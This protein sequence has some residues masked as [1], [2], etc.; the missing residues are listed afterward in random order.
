M[1]AGFRN[2]GN[3]IKCRKIDKEN[4]P[5][6][7]LPGGKGCLQFNTVAPFPNISTSQSAT[8]ELKV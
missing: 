7:S 5:I 1:F 3:V 2:L 4:P 8:L 6:T